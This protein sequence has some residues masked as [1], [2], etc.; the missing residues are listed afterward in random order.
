MK[1]EFL[2]RMNKI[3]KD[4]EQLSSGSGL[5]PQFSKRYSGSFMTGVLFEHDLI[6]MLEA[7]DFECIDQITFFLEAL[8]D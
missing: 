5:R 6:E 8:T 3:L 4:T 2:S 1:M 7:S